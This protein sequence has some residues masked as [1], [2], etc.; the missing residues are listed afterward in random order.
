M[1]ELVKVV[2]RKSTDSEEF[3]TLLRRISS[4]SREG[5]EVDG[6]SWLAALGPA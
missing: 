4:Q 6:N 3:R 1:A 2:S 5:M